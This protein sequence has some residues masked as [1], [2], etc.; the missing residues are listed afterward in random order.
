V[1]DA[2][3]VGSGFG[4]LGAALSLAERGARVALF[5]TLA[6]PGGCASSFTR[7]GCR[8]EAG[9]TLLSGLDA[10][11]LFGR[12]IARHRLPVAI[13]RLDPLVTLR[14]DGLEIAIPRDRDALV[15]RLA[16][17]PG[18]PAAG[19]RAFFAEQRRVADTLW[20]L[21]DDPALLPLLDLPALL[22][23]ARRLPRYLA[24]LPLVGRPLESVLGR[25]GVAGFAPL[26]LY[27][28]ALCRIT[29]QCDAGAAE[30]PFALAAMDYYWRGA[31]HVRGGVG[32]LAT[33]L[34]DAVHALGG[35]VRMADRVRRVE[36]L[37]R[38]RGFRVVSRAGEVTARAVVLNLLPQGLP[39]HLPEG[40]ALPPRIAR[41]GAAL[42]RGYGA[43]MLYATVRPPGDAP[44]GPAHLQ[45]VLDAARP[46]TRGNHV[47]CSFSGAEDGRRA[48]PGLRTMTASTHVPLEGFL[49]LSP[50][51]RAREVAAIQARMRETI[52]RR[53]PE[54]AAGV[55]AEM[56]ASPRTFARFTG[57][58]EGRVG[59]P[60]RTAGLLSYRSLGPLEALPGLFLVGDSVFP[61]QSTLAAA[62]GGVRAAEAIERAAPQR[63]RV[64]SRD[65]VPLRAPAASGTVPVA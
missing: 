11:Q 33:A 49:G 38:G 30:A 35:A 45:L 10:H 13:D 8:F 18:A 63:D 7:D 1:L 3:V 46:L 55:A 37:G 40:T 65:P 32:V 42:D 2:A 61:G 6:Y 20:A 48:P 58:P 41:I 57:R 29:V 12:W 16:A 4:G 60:P 56:T 31:G 59:G 64:P 5:E 53:A 51:E 27:L 17:L 28:D 19:I 44:D 22:G 39:A 25:H 21:F 34:A 15:T 26:R 62:L 54:W 50:E 36:P 14:A 47:F 23:H 52:A 9:A 43:A 24:L